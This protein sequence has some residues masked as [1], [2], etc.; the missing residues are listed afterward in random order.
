M[1]TE[2]TKSPITITWD[3][4]VSI[5]NSQ[6]KKQELLKAFNSNDAIH[7]DI[8]QV[9]DLDISAVQLILASQK[10]ALMRK[11]EFKIVGEVPSN[12]IDFFCRIGIPMNKLITSE[13]LSTEILETITGDANA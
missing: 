9:E 8:S 6:K 7:L 11:K 2:T 12:F 13:Q 10:E 4:T 5:E 1:A 3:D